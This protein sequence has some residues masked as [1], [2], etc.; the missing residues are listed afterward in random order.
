M[1][2]C[3]P[4]IIAVHGLCP[5]ES[6]HPGHIASFCCCFSVM[7]LSR[8]AHFLCC[9][10]TCDCDRHRNGLHHQESEIAEVPGSESRI[11][12]IILGACGHQENEH[13]AVCLQGRQSK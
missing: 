9:L 11:A 5:S 12:R 1:I 2:R 8:A 7:V 6:V 13:I 3:L 10:H 4:G